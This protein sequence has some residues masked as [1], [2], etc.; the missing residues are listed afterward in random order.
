MHLS[1][2]LVLKSISFRFLISEFIKQQFREEVAGHQEVVA[3][4]ERAGTF[5][6]YFGRKQDSVYVRTLLMSTKLRWK[7]L[8]TRV[9]EKGRALTQACREDKRVSVYHSV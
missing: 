5:L 3:R 1:Q 9:H 6:R 4:L 7:K 8:I 2:F